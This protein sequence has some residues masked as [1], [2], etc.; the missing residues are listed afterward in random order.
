M[1]HI[2]ITLLNGEVYKETYETYDECVTFA[3]F[4]KDVLLLTIIKIK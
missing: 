4:T 3:I 2:T 1:Y